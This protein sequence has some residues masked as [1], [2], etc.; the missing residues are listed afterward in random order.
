MLHFSECGELC[1][2][3]MHKWL[4]VWRLSVLFFSWWRNKFHIPTSP[5]CV[6]NSV[7]TQHR[8]E[9][10]SG[11]LQMVLWPGFARSATFFLMKEYIPYPHISIV[12]PSL[13][14]DTTQRRE[15]AESDVLHV[16]AFVRC[17]PSTGLPTCLSTLVQWEK[18]C[19]M[20]FVDTTSTCR[21]SYCSCLAI[22]DVV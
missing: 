22:R 10:E 16:R 4:V 7:T 5:L 3:E 13:C 14:Y 1:F 2:G 21:C 6:P 11:L 19:C 17:S 15:E 20:G 8:E 18:W 12:C 9:A